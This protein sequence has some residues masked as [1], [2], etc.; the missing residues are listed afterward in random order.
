MQDVKVRTR[1]FFEV[2][3]VA[4]G[5]EGLDLFNGK[6]ILPTTKTEVKKFQSD[7]GIEEVVSNTTDNFMAV[8]ARMQVGVFGCGQVVSFISH[9]CF[10]VF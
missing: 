1:H 5:A 3:A 2:I 10:C 7:T 4:G 9:I 8:S 6:V